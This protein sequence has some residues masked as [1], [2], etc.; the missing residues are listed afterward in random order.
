MFGNSIFNAAQR[1]SVEEAVHEGL[2][3]VSESTMQVAD[4]ARTNPDKMKEVAEATKKIGEQVAELTA[5]ASDAAQNG[6]RMRAAVTEAAKT[7]DWF[8]GTLSGSGV[9]G[10]VGSGGN[11]QTIHV[12]NGA[13]GTLWEQ[14]GK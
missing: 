9:C 3:S 8:G 7:A 11:V 5:C 2:N 12:G 1:V 14:Y 4:Y 6:E 13:F 10:S